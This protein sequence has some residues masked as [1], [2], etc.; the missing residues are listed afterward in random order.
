MV[1]LPSLNKYDHLEVVGELE[2]LF[3][4]E[5]TSKSTCWMYFQSPTPTRNRKTYECI[6][7]NND[8]A[9]FNRNWAGVCWDR[10]AGIGT[11]A[12]PIR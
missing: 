1:F 4:R 5:K 3:T 7:M 9:F 12:R 8:D 10:W 2:T 6:S 11:V